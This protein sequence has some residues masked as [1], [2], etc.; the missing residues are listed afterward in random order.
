MFFIGCTTL[1]AAQTSARLDISK[2]GMVSVSAGEGLRLTA[3]ALPGGLGCRAQ[4]LFLMTTGRS[5]GRSLTVN[6]APGTSA[7][8][9]LDVHDN[10]V[11]AVKPVAWVDPQ[12]PEKDCALKLTAIASAGAPPID[13]AVPRHCLEREC[14]GE[15]AG[16]L[17]GSRLRIYVF[18]EDGDR[19]RAQL[20]FKL[21]RD[22]V[23][24]S[25]KYVNLMS[26]HGDSLEWDSGEDIDVR[27]DDRVVPVVTFHEGDACIASAEIVSG[28]A[29]QS[30]TPVPV[31]FYESSSVG[32]ALDPAS[33]P[34][35]INTLAAETAR[36]PK[37]MWSASALAQAFY[38][39]GQRDRAIQL[40]TSILKSDPKAAETWYLLAKFQ[41][42]KQD[43]LF[44]LQSLIR[45]LDLKPGDPRALSAEGVTLARLHRFDEAERI[46]KPLLESPGTRTALAL[47]SWAE[48][49]SGQQQYS[50]ALPFVEESDRLHP[51]CKF[52][53]YLKASVLSGLDRT[54]ES[55]A[56]AER[57]LQLDPDFTANHLLLVRLYAKE[58][59]AELAEKQSQWLRENLG[60]TN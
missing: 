4:L 13:I 53:L 60:K 43:Y 59:D 15:S 56:V 57:V 31:E 22:A 55:I 17:E 45:Y 1:V 54:T 33:L 37:D 29:S 50:A 18:A 47:N 38:R 39:E 25:S 27:P 51:N 16:A 52:T 23:A 9:D 35:T 42:Q 49:L 24:G 34:T 26:D 40:L 41:F 30:F 58:G 5:A 6:L 19:C 44:A 10:L 2:Y 36:D 8:D 7:Y 48:T 11:S 28:A 32:L 3:D 46:L 20:G 12:A 14:H 21:P